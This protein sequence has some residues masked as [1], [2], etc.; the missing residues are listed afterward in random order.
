MEDPWRIRPV[1]RRRRVS[2]P[3]AQAPANET[4]ATKSDGPQSIPHP[5][6]T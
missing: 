5:N 4:A 6:E 3:L 2:F 1:P